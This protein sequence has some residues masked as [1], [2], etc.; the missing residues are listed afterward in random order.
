MPNLAGGQH[1]EGETGGR[2][3]LMSCIYVVGIYVLS[4]FN[5]SWASGT[6]KSSGLMR[7]CSIQTTEDVENLEILPKACK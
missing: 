1:F 3:G 2:A 4:D 5:G 7:A 6:L